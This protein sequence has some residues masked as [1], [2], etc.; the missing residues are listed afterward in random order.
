MAVVDIH[1]KNDHQGEEKG[2]GEEFSG[3][4]EERQELVLV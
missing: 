2:H 3:H 4:L 1:W